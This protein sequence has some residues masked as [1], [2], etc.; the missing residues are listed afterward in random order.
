MECLRCKLPIDGQLEQ[1]TCISDVKA[2]TAHFYCYYPKGV[3][4]R[5]LPFPSHALDII[6]RLSPERARYFFVRPE[7]E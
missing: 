4:D 6:Q 3:P 5:S 7:E 1:L 2:T